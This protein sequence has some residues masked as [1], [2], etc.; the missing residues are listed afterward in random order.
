MFFEKWTDNLKRNAEWYDFSLIKLSVFSGTML[1]LT[2][3]PDFR[4]IALSIDW[5][6]YLII[7]IIAIIPLLKKMFSD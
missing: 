7:Y 5:Y 3:W 4:R 2:I 6:I 1:L